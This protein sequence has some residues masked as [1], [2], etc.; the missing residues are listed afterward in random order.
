MLAAAGCGGSSAHVT[1]RVT[2]QG[3]PVAGIILF[4]PKEEEGKTTGPAV[5]APLNEDGTYELQLKN[6][7]KYIIVITPA[8]VNFHPK[9]GEADYPCERSPLEREVTAGENDITIELAKRTR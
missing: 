7:G 9:A 5:T 1:G 2:C 6:A 8:N 4:S 3:K